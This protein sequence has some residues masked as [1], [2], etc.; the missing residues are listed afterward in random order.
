MHS[1]KN[2]SAASRSGYFLWGK[3]NILLKNA[4]RFLMV[5]LLFFRFFLNRRYFSEIY[6]PHVI[7]SIKFRLKQMW[8]LTKA[9]TEMKCDT[10]QTVKLE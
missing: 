9:I 3:Q 2:H 6:I 4:F 1:L 7:T 10:E 8:R 5:M